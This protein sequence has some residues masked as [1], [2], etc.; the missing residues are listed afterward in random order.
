[1]Y[2]EFLW[3]FNAVV[4]LYYLSVITLKR[5]V[6][7]AKSIDLFNFSLEKKYFTKIKL[8]MIF[9]D[10]LDQ[11]YLNFWFL[12]T[13]SAI[14]LDKKW[15]YISNKQILISMSLNGHELQLLIRLVI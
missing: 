5:L 12:V 11:L 4:L 1:M 8:L 7:P 2:F 10:S 14:Q 6:F 13:R 9:I 3:I 15:F